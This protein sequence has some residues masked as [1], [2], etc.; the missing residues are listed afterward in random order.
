MATRG[1]DFANLSLMDALD[2]AILVEDEALERYDDFAAQMD[3]H[4]TPD[5]AKFFRYMAEN[6]A[7]HGEQLSVRRAELFGSAPPSVSRALI[8]DIEAPDFDAVRAFMSPR[9]AMKAALASE[10]KAHAFFV[11]ALPVL[12]NAEVKALFEELRDEEILHQDLVNVELAKL[13]PDNGLSED[14]FVDEPAAQ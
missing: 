12:K 5:A 2:L 3:Q 13:P 10:V 9:Q 14:D 4:R 11:A 6:E 7:K 8:F 1:I